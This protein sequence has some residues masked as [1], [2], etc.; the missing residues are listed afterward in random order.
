MGNAASALPLPSAVSAATASQSPKATSAAAA[1]S[2]PDNNIHSALAALVAKISAQQAAAAIAPTSPQ[3]PQPGVV[4]PGAVAFAAAPPLPPTPFST[5]PLAASARNAN[6]TIAGAQAEYILAGALLPEMRALPNAKTVRVFVAAGTGQ[7]HQLP[8]AARNQSYNQTDFSGERDEL[9]RRVWPALARFCVAIGLDFAVVDFEWNVSDIDIHANKENERSLTRLN[10]ALTD[11]TITIFVGFLGDKY[12]PASL[13]SSLT[14]TEYEDLKEA[15]LAS[16]DTE[17]LVS[18]LL[19]LWYILDTNATGDNGS[20]ILQPISR[21]MGSLMNDPDHRED[22]EQAWELVRKQIVAAIGKKDEGS[23]KP[24]AARVASSLTDLK[25]SLAA[26]R[27][28]RDSVI[29]KFDRRTFLDL[30]RTAI[31]NSTLAASFIDMDIPSFPAS[32]SPAPPQ[33]AKDAN[34]AITRL[35]SKHRATRF[36][37]IPWRADL[38]GFNPARESMHATYLDTLCEDVAR[39]VSESIVK[40]LGASGRN[41]NSIF[42]SSKVGW[43]VEEV[44]R[45]GVAVLEE[46]ERFVGRTELVEEISD[47]LTNSSAVSVLVLYGPSGVGKTALTSKIVETIYNTCPEAVL[48][49]RLIGTS[50]Q[51][52]DS[53]SL[54]RSICAQ[55]SSVYGMAELKDKIEIEASIDVDLSETTG[56]P[57]LLDKLGNLDQWP[58]ITLDGLKAGFEI[59]LKLAEESK[60]LFL[61]MDALDELSPDDAGGGLEWLPAVLPPYVKLVLTTSPTSRKHATFS[62]IK[63]KY[64]SLDASKHKYIEIPELSAVDVENMIARLML[65]DKRSLQPSQRAM[66]TNKCLATK[67]PLYIRTAWTLHAR[68]W[69]SFESDS[70]VREAVQAETVPGLLEGFFETLEMRLGRYFVARAAAYITAAKQGVSRMELEDLLSLDEAVMNEVFKFHT[71]PIRRI[72]SVYVERFIE[73]MGD[74]LVQKQVHGVRAF[75]WSHPQVYRVAEDRYLEQGQAAKVH[76]IFVNYWE[77]KFAH[78]PKP[79][80]DWRDFIS[81][82]EHRYVIDQSLLIFGKPNVRRISAVVWH[83]LG[84]GPTGFRQAAKTLQD[85]SHL[86]T[87]VHGGLLWDVLACYRYAM[88]LDYAEGGIVS[89]LNDCKSSKM[90]RQ[91]LITYDYLDYRFLLAHA[92]ILLNDPNRLVPVAVNLYEGSVVA[93]EARKWIL[94]NSPGLNWIE[95][96]NRPAARGEPIA[97]LRGND[98]GVANDVMTVTGCDTYDE[99]VVLAG[100]RAFDNQPVVFLYDIEQVEAVSV[101]GGRAKLLA[102]CNFLSNNSSGEILEHGFALVCSFSRAGTLIAVAGRSLVIMD[103]M[104]LEIH[105]VGRDHALPEGDLITGIAWTAQDGCV[106]T[107][108]DGKMPGR[109]GLWDAKSLILLKVVDTTLNP[110]KP[111]CSTSSTF[112]FWDEKQGSF[113]VF[114]IDEFASDP[115]S[116]NNVQ[117]I[118]NKP[119]TIPAPDNNARFAMSFGGGYT[120]IAEETG[121]GYLLIDMKGK[122]PV[123]RL[124][125]E[126]DMVCYIS[127]AHD[128]KRV[129]IVPKDS[130]VIFIH[131][132]TQDSKPSKESH[133]LYTYRHLGTIL[134]VDPQISPVCCRFS[135]SGKTILTGGEF[136]SV[137]VWSVNELGDHATVAFKPALTTTFQMVV[138]VKSVSYSA[139]YIGWAVNEEHAAVSF[140]DKKAV[141]VLQTTNVATAKKMRRV[142]FSRKDVVTGF[143]SH[144]TKPIVATVTNNGNL[145]LLYAELAYHEKGWTGAIRSVLSRRRE[146]GYKVSFSVMKEGFIS[147]SSI[148]FLDSASAASNSNRTTSGES[149]QIL[150]FAVGYEDGTVSIYD[151]NSA[152]SVMDLSPTVTIKLNTGRVTS[153]VPTNVST[154]RRVA[155]TIEDSVLVLWDGVSS[156]AKK[157]VVLVH[158]DAEPSSVTKFNNRRSVTSIKSISGTFERNPDKPIPVAFSNTQE[159]LLATG[160]TDGEITIWNTDAKVKRNLL[161]HTAEIFPA[162]IVAIAWASDDA[163][164]VSMTEDKRIAIH[165]T[166]TGNVVWIHDLWMI[167]SNVKSAA[168]TNGARELAVLDHAGVL[169]CIRLHGDWPTSLN[170]DVFS[171]TRPSDS[172]SHPSISHKAAFP[173]APDPEFAEFIAWSESIS[174]SLAKARTSRSAIHWELSPGSNP[175]GRVGLIRL[176]DGLPRGCFEVVCNVEV[177]ANLDAPLIPLKF[178]C[179]SSG[180]DQMVDPELDVVHGFSRLFPVEEQRQLAGKGTVCVRLGFIKT[181]C[182]LNSCCIILTRIPGTGDP[183]PCGD[184]HFIPADVSQY[185]D[186]YQYPADLADA[187]DHLSVDFE[188]FERSQ[189]LNSFHNVVSGQHDLTDLHQADE[190]ADLIVP[191]EVSIKNSEGNVL[192]GS[193]GDLMWEIEDEDLSPLSGNPSVGGA[194]DSKFGDE[195][196]DD[197]LGGFE[198]FENPNSRG[199][200]GGEGKKTGNRRSMR[201]SVLEGIAGVRSGV[202]GVVG[203]ILSN[204]PGGAAVAAGISS[205]K[206]QQLSQQLA[207]P[208][209]SPEDIAREM[210]EARRKGH[211][212]QRLFDEDDERRAAQA[213]KQREWMARQLEMENDAK[214]RDALMRMQREARGGAAWDADLA[215]DDLFDD[216]DLDG[217]DEEVKIAARRLMHEMLEKEMRQDL[218]LAIEGEE[219]DYEY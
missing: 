47:L 70:L 166:V 184:V 107:A 86:G 83:Q 84:I 51:S 9:V 181:S 66:F 97:T 210:Q 13:P 192:A 196:D 195:E 156:D 64:P 80:Q 125:I 59:A 28:R 82:A 212:Q 39:A 194:S 178:V 3:M 214:R 174:D 4:S 219:D 1:S 131:G 75:F 187:F 62:N 157:V 139:G 101:G 189:G 161:I 25:I 16:P 159:Q 65:G 15:L 140:S 165:N 198:K 6:A 103:A 42:R 29:G 41:T 76:S 61:I 120:I 52:M 23:G 190:F 117:F 99:R 211:E 213:A 150:S 20:Y 68:K 36:Y 170:A 14:P 102:K 168:F 193:S 74:C 180:H 185:R 122:R 11:S 167:T 148:A 104:D 111:I 96:I 158:Q 153:I 216:P 24:A 57:S 217:V 145:T 149:G 71:M 46:V 160:E 77:A 44:V 98:S 124:E 129:A 50:Y 147:P 8:K 171:P 141:N 109:L 207:R 67:M 127:I 215:D 115:D 123:A 40:Q 202:T 89:Q 2:H 19:D 136:G 93:D 186:E 173:P 7:I 27:G 132:I 21:V 112:G 38:G 126:V 5:S 130:K 69:S 90:L 191:H 204:I 183:I 81:K 119:Q 45:H 116:G 179:W 176:T 110:R 49:T 162:P 135:R 134:G 10:E 37:A 12:G 142:G 172:N 55:I 146:G 88:S 95:W 208:R 31:E 22:A 79:Y 152:N 106:V 128:G 143:A 17:H 209:I 72:P 87:A 108:S 85:I 53:V 100:I 121:K 205:D 63:S 58:P 182:R 113:V 26:A 155:I 154:S 200:R 48:I 43:V 133:N 175:N 56:E 54:L 169:G 144:S 35:R 105:Q 32:Q 18:Q 118:H 30:K 188:E 203:G 151:W 33:I 201:M 138:P 137:R 114:N 218:D 91:A 197:V 164:L 199:K 94:A 177:P 163:A 60:P 34:A 73:E 92:E 206:Q 78:D